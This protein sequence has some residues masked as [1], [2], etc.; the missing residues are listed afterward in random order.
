MNTGLP[1]TTAGAEK[2]TKQD[3]VTVA[4]SPNLASVARKREEC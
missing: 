4:V 3:G 2:V 1:E